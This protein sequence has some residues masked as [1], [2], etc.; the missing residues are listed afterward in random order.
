MNDSL[1]GSRGSKTDLASINKLSDLKNRDR[2]AE[3][4]QKARQKADPAE[5]AGL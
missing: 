5:K 1:T 2:L 3:S 4:L